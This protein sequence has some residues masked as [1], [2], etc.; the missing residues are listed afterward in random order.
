[1][2][3]VDPLTGA[4]YNLKPEKI[5]QPLSAAQAQVIRDG[6]GM[7]VVLA[8]QATEHERAQMVRVN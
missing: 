4:M 7:L 5:E 3:I 2:L 8:S 1:M 6:K